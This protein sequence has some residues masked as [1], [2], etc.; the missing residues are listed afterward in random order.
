MRVSTETIGEITLSRQAFPLRCPHPGDTMNLPIRLKIWPLAAC[1]GFLALGC[2]AQ[3]RPDCKPAPEN[4]AELVQIRPRFHT[5][6]GPLAEFDPCHKSSLL[7]VPTRWN[8]SPL[9][10]KPPL[11]IIAHGGGGLGMLERNLATALQ[12]KDIATL[13]FDA[14]HLNGFYQGY[15]FWGSQATNE[16]RQRMIY[17]A[18][19]GAYEWALTQSDKIDTRSIYLQGVSNGAAVVTN[20]ASV[21]SPENVKAVIAEGLPGM[22]IGLPDT[23][24]VPVK[25]VFGKL[26]NYGGKHPED[27]MWQRQES[28][29]V[30]RAPSAEVPA[31]NAAQCNARQNP[32]NLTEKP[33]DWM[34]RL[35]AQKADI[36]VWFY[37]NA[38]HG[39]F[40]GP[41]DRKMLTYGT[42]NVTFSWTGS[43]NSAKEK[44]LADLLKLIQNPPTPP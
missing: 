11:V 40:Q 22:G 38:A 10:I 1:L 39:I 7:T 33:I 29:F 21:V 19:K 4:V 9:A 43:E 12:R 41:I 36:D 34:N 2:A 31:G 42:D 25:L 32:T 14:Y 6:K 35:K 5:V 23:V 15:P 24:A 8:G 20:L 16:S 30:N 28:C 17:K 3:P 44:M 37:D 18:A 26:D 27:W 13:V